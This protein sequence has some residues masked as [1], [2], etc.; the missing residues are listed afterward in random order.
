MVR[1]EKNF[2]LRKYNTFGLD[3]KAMYYFEFT[4][5]EDLPAF[6][7][8]FETWQEVPLLLLGG[9]S[10]LL[11]PGD[12]KGLVIHAHIPGI[13]LLKEDRYHVWLEAGAGENWDNFVSYCVNRGYGGLE[14]LSLIPG[15]AGAAPVQNIGAYGVEV[16]DFV[17]SVKG[18]DLQIFQFRE[19]YAEVCGFDYRSSIFK[20]E[21]KGR[22]IVTSVVFKLD[23]FPEFRLNY[24]DLKAE[25][26]KLGGEN[27]QCVR[28]AVITIRQRKLPDPKD[29]GN[30]GSF[31]KNP[32]V[33][34][35]KAKEL[36]AAFPSIPLYPAGKGLFKVAAAWLIEQ[37]GWK[38][39]REGDAGVH[40][41]QA[42]VLVN[43]GKA[44][45]EQLLSL[46]RKI[47]QS[48]MEQYSVELES[49]VH[50]VE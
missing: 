18:F 42:L 38:G 17:V 44:T 31:F 24:G 9:G 7:C 34:D 26:K 11:F 8:T 25:V 41:M 32:V 46:S 27:L 1:F 21:L 40:E 10:N 47:R 4:E 2:S 23:K 48:V 29:L 39:Y 28:E 13:K 6:L 22:F 33:S 37:C 12:F 45:G 43:Y 35:A 49:E 14:N 19:I 36:K 5:E 16:K 50:V 30:A 15:N 3:A 20:K